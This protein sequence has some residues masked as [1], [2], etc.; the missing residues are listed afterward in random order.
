M[1]EGEVMDFLNDF[2]FFSELLIVNVIVEDISFKM[3]G[4]VSGDKNRFFIVFIKLI[5]LVIIY[6]FLRNFD[7][8]KYV[9]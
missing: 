3:S 7:V 6:K 5:L 9:K 2:N 1:G 8:Y 4:G